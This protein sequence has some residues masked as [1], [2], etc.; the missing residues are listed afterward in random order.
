MVARLDSP[1]KFLT[2]HSFHRD[3]PTMLED[4][5]LSDPP[6]ARC[7]GKLE[8]CMRHSGVLGWERFNA[9]AFDAVAEQVQPT[10]L[11]RPR[12][13]RRPRLT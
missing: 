7:S 3:Q 12:H 9:A 6:P 1:D 4:H 8:H 10:S 13:A 5:H 11:P 2:S